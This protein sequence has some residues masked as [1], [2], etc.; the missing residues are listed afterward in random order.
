MQ[1]LAVAGSSGPRGET[2]LQEWLNRDLPA[3]VGSRVL[4]VDR[5]IADRWGT[6]RAQA[7]AMGRPLAV[8]D[9]LLAATAL[10]HNLAIVSRNAADFVPAGVAVINPWKV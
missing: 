1:V 4:T 7:Q 5:P 9:G 8:V 2:R 6:L 3:W 10:Q